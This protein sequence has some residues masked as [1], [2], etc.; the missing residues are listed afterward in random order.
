ME[1][2]QNWWILSLIVAFSLISATQLFDYAGLR[3]SR[4]FAN[5]VIFST[6]VFGFL[7]FYTGL[8]TAARLIR[9]KPGAGSTSNS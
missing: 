2:K 5:G 1:R 7:Y 8:L 3:I 9:P 4:P 6:S